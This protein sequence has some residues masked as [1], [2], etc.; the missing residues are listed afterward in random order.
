MATHAA[1]AFGGQI[2]GAD[3]AASKKVKLEPAIALNIDRVL[4]RS[5]LLLAHHE[6]PRRGLFCSDQAREIHSRR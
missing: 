3:E 4:T 5:S 6:Q 2:T 1:S